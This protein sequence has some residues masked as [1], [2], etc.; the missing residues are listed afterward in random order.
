MSWPDWIEFSIHY[1]NK[2]VKER[3]SKRSYNRIGSRTF[4]ALVFLCLLG[5]GGLG[6]IIEGPI[7]GWIADAYGWAGPFYLMVGMSLLGSVTMLRASRIDQS[8]KQAQFMG[9]ITSE[10]AWYCF[11]AGTIEYCG[12]LDHCKR[13]ILRLKYDGSQNSF[14]GNPGF[15]QLRW[16]RDTASKDQSMESQRIWIGCDRLLPWLL[17]FSRALSACRK[18]LPDRC[19]NALKRPLVLRLLKV[20]SARFRGLVGQVAL[21]TR[22]HHCFA[23]VENFATTFLVSLLLS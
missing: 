8:I 1:A 7:V 16:K 17:W 4:N 9:T 15:L 13:G 11:E 19:T 22:R 5:F 2:K 18:R 23:H 6:P 20:S 12:K 3:S 21:G 10:T 14:K